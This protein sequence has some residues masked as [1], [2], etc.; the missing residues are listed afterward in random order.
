[1]YV[2]ENG[3]ECYDVEDCYS[4][5]IEVQA[6][7]NKERDDTYEDCAELVSELEAIG[8]TADYYL[9]AEIFDLRKK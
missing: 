1:M 5:P 2:N 8:Y 9:D 7:L 4:L 6:V 3:F